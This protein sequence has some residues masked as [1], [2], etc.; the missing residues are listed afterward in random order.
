MTTEALHLL[1][2]PPSVLRLLPRPSRLLSRSG[3][4]PHI[5]LCISRQ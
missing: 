2:V 5:W 3:R 1:S 4:Y